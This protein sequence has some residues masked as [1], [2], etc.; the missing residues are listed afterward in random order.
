MQL[1]SLGDRREYEGAVK[2]GELRRAQEGTDLNVPS[3]VFKPEYIRPHDKTPGAS[4][5]PRP[6]SLNKE[7]AES[8]P[9]AADSDPALGL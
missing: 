8:F 9:N 7:S 6:R 1:S 2:T 4:P 3:V 5:P